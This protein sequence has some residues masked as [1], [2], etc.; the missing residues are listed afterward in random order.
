M[1]ALMRNLEFF[2]FGLMMNGFVLNFEKKLVLL[3]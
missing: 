3:S 2:L 1:Q